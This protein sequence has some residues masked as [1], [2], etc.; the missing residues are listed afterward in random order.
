MSRRDWGAQAR[1]ST[2]RIA[3]RA[4]FRAM[5]QSL[6]RRL[7]RHR[8]RIEAAGLFAAVLALTACNYLIA[9]RSLI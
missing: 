2:R 6:C 7:S 4:L 9:L 8:D 5:R 3:R 1:A